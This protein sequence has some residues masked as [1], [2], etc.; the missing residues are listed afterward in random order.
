MEINKN[1]IS[2]NCSE[3]EFEAI[4]LFVDELNR[5]YTKIIVNKCSSNIFLGEIRGEAWVE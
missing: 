5:M 4:V 2:F 3:K 1:I